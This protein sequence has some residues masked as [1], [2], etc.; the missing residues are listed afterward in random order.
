MVIDRLEAAIPVPAVV[1]SAPSQQLLSSAAPEI[2]SIDA[3]GNLVAHRAGRAEIRSAND[4]ATLLVD[5]HVAT[6]LRVEPAEPTIAMGA[7]VPLRVFSDD[8]EVP[9]AAVSW[10]FTDP[11]IARVDG[12]SLIGGHTQG[13]ARVIATYGGQVVQVPVRVRDGAK[14]SIIEVRAQHRSLRVGAIEQLS[15]NVPNGAPLEW[16]SSDPAVLRPLRNGLYFAQKRGVANACAR[17]ERQ[18]SCV[19]IAVR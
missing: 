13:S 9:A 16:T 14:R 5:V 2:V 11:E 17:A 7:A 19:Q 10:A 6:Y 8:G 15:T 18:A 12:S 1:G 3:A 4:P